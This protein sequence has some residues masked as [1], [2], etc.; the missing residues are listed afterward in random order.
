MARRENEEKLAKVRADLY[1][2]L[3]DMGAHEIIG[4]V[5]QFAGM[6]LVVDASGHKSSGVA[7][8][9]KMAHF[10]SGMRKIFSSSKE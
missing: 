8:S 1:E 4:V 5:S 9:A 3:G 7:Q 6:T 2:S 10:V